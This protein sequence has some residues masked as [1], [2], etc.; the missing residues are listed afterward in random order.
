MHERCLPDD[1]VLYLTW[2]TGNKK[3]TTKGLLPP[4]L[5]LYLD[6]E[7]LIRDG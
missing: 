1:L 5:V 3:P 4:Y 2:P 6:F 7:A